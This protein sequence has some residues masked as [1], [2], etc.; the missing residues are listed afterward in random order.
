MGLGRACL[1]QVTLVRGRRRNLGLSAPPRRN[2]LT[3]LGRTSTAAA[4]PRRRSTGSRARSA[5]QGRRRRSSGSDG[6]DEAHF[7][8]AAPLHWR[9]LEGH[10]G[11]VRERIPPRKLRARLLRSASLA[12]QRSRGAHWRHSGRQHSALALSLYSRLS[13]PVDPIAVHRSWET[14]PVAPPIDGYC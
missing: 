6:E 4:E 11:G 14:W 13:S 1:A 5:G 12:P 10:Q 9:P 8:G 7:S 2:T 3:A